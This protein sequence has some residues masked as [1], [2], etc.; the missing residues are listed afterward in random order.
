MKYIINLALLMFATAAFAQTAPKTL[1]LNWTN[2]D[3]AYGPACTNPVTVK[4]CLQSSTASDITSL[5]P[6]ILSAAISPSAT[7]FTYTLPTSTSFGNHSYVVTAAGI[8]A[9]GNATT[10]GPSNVAIVDIE[11]KLNA[12]TGLAVNAQ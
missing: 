5:T 12:P 11:P 7:S 6:V 8:D 10:S 2:A 1:V 4:P 9:N 3:A